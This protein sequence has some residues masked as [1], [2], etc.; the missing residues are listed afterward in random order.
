LSILVLLS[1]SSLF[2]VDIGVAVVVV[3]DGVVVGNIRR[4][5][6]P[7]IADEPL[8][9]VMEDE[10]DGIL[11]CWAAATDESNEIIDNNEINTDVHFI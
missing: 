6:V 3:D 1:E 8:V 11:F 4:R 5:G 9:N 10:D 7:N 2:V